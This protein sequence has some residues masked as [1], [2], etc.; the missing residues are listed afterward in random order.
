MQATALDELLRIAEGYLQSRRKQHVKA[1]WFFMALN[2]FLFCPPA[3][4]ILGVWESLKLHEQ[5]DYLDCMW[6]QLENMRQNGWKERH[7]SRHYANFETKYAEAVSHR[8]PNIKLPAF[9][10]ENYKYPLPRVVF[11]LFTD[12][13]CPEEVCGVCDRACAFNPQPIL[14]ATTCR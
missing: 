2:I 10:A 13:D 5:K 14:G 8:L 1:S 6:L 9:E 3:L 7:I 12:T 11:R 4:Q